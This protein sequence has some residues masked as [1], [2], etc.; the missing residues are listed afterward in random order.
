M[1]DRYLPRV[2]DEGFHKITT[3]LIGRGNWRVPL[4][5]ADEHFI[6]ANH[7]YVFEDNVGIRY[8]DISFSPIERNRIFGQ[9][10]GNFDFRVMRY[11]WTLFIASN[12]KDKYTFSQITRKTLQDLKAH[13]LF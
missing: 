1:T 8:S 2:N 3:D 4:N 11:L 10:P 12:E 13:V 7:G 9:Q 5:Y 6:P